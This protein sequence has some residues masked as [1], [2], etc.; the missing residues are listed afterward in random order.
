MPKTLHRIQSEA[1][2]CRAEQDNHLHLQLQTLCLMSPR[3]QL[4]LLTQIELDNDG[5]P[6][7]TLCGTALQSLLPQ[8]VGISRIDPPQIQN[9]VLALVKLYMVSDCPD[10]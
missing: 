10:L 2:Q 8:S 9:T 5:D 1:A 4:A 6:Q 7:V 3:T